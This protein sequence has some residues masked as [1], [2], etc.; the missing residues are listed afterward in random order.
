MAC[1]APLSIATVALGACALPPPSQR[2]ALARDQAFSFIYP[3]VID[4][5]RK[6]GAE[7]IPFS[8]LADEP[9]PDRADSCWL[10]GGY[11]ELTLMHSQ[12]H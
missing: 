9:P 7:I 3:H 11:A 5:W 8:P 12:P 10:R 6:A 2:I 4:A 1:A